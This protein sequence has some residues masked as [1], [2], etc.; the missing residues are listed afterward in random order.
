MQY[1]GSPANKRRR[2]ENNSRGIKSEASSSRSGGA[3]YST[4][5]VP[6][7]KLEA[8]SN[9]EVVPQTHRA[10]ENDIIAICRTCTSG[11]LTPFKLE[12][13]T[14]IQAKIDRVF[15]HGAKSFDIISEIKTK[16]PHQPPTSYSLTLRPEQ[17]RRIGELQKRMK[18][19]Q[20][21]I[22]AQRVKAEPP[23]TPRGRKIK[24]CRSR[25]SKSPS[26]PAQPLAPAENVVGMLTLN[27]ESVSAVVQ[28][29]SNLLA[30][31]NLKFSMMGGELR[32]VDL[33]T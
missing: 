25:S 2:H 27:E 14:E 5:A 22:A 21:Q 12:Q 20:T 3:S 29:A 28:A 1:A 19:A 10:P 32:L 13:L 7:I 17:N 24:K 4:N 8:P 33:A 11:I 18:D 15:N 16:I 31:R 26:V 9:A 6:R 23:S 30:G